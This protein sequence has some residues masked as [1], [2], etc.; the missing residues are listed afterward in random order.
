MNEHEYLLG[1]D[2]GSTKVAVVLAKQKIQNNH[3]ML[4]VLGIGASRNEG[5]HRGNINNPIKTKEAILAAFQMAATKA[6]RPDLLNHPLYATVN[7]SGNHLE[8]TSE[9]GSVTCKSASVK[10]EDVGFLFENMKQS[11]DSDINQIIHLLPLKFAVGDQ[12]DIVDPVGHIGLKLSG[13]FKIVTAKKTALQQI[14]DSIQK[15]KLQVEDE[16][17]FA[18]SPLASSLAILSEDHKKLGVVM[19]DIGGGTTD[20]AIYHD[21]LLQHTTVLPFGGNHI[22]NDIKEGCH[23]TIESAEEAKTFISE[24]NP[25]ECSLN[26]LLVVPTAE[27]IPPIEIVA[28]NIVLI[29]RARLREI[30]ALVLAEIRKAGFERKLNAGIVLTGGTT[31]IKGIESVFREITGMHVQVGKPKN[32]ERTHSAIHDTVLDD[33]SYTTALGLAWA[34]IKPIDKRVKKN[35][36]EP[37]IEAKKPSSGWR[38]PNFG[39]SVKDFDIKEQWSYVW[40]GLTKDDLKGE[41]RF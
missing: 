22:T 39:K 29:T 37:E 3:L 23:L 40:D 9:R 10:G 36:I 34:S 14:R 19:V 15:A 12:H 18:A 41:D 38:I 35:K 33:P 24:T 27:G 8:T 6:E 31:K 11:F 32:V 30:A 20:I 1:I 26:Q 13:D 5:V 16:D 4:Q 28:R 25:N 7:V 2:I 21:G 17:G